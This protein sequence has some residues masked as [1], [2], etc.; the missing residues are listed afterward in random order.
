MMNKLA[1]A[2]IL[3]GAVAGTAYAQE[4]PST[5]TTTPNATI[6][7]TPNTSTSTTTGLA[8]PILSEVLSTIPSS[9]TTVTNFYKQ[10]VYDRSD[11]K[12]GEISDVLVSKEGKI[13]GFIMSVGGFLGIGEK[14]VAVPFD[15]IQSTQRNGSWWL[16]MNAT[17]N[18]LE[19]APGFKYD[20]AKATWVP[21]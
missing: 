4:P 15:A 5:V 19:Q 20:R 10:N 21:A 7:T 2:A 9:A 8:A 17:K 13:D 16:T 18:Q 14:S 11:S 3:A 1:A 6:T 12:V